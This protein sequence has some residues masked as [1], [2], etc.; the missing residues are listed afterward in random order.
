ME[1]SRLGIDIHIYLKGRE[2]LFALKNKEIVEKIVP[3]EYEEDMK[4]STLL[5][6]SAHLTQ[7]SILVFLMP[8]L[9]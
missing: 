4:L 8:N 3:E 9:D 2:A 6:L 1:R 5:L 7:P